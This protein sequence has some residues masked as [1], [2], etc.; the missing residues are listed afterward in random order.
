MYKTPLSSI[1]LSFKGFS[2]NTSLSP[3]VIVLNAYIGED[4]E[5]EILLDEQSVEDRPELLTELSTQNG[6]R[7]YFYEINGAVSI[8]TKRQRVTISPLFKEVSYD[9]TTYPIRSRQTKRR[10]PLYGKKAS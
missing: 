4:E 3:E 10:V 1:R 2:N 7:F 6:V 8:T 9:D 5:E